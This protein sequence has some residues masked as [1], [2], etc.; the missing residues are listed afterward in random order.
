MNELLFCPFCGCDAERVDI[1]AA[2]DENAGG[3]FVRC[4]RCDASTAIHFDRK[5][6]LTSAWN[7]RRG[8]I[9]SPAASAVLSERFRQ[10]DGE[11]H[12][13]AADDTYPGG[14]LA[15]AAASYALSAARMALPAGLWPWH[16]SWWKPKDP[17]RDLVRAG[18]LILAEIE[19]I[20]RAA[21]KEATDGR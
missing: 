16:A 4:R 1:D 11:G 20:D 10:V 15:R 14:L 3:S 18:A 5:E 7:S 21:E 8:A 17:R 12:T 13:P 9:L 6:N 2:D 19:R